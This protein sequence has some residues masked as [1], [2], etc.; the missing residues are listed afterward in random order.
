VEIRNHFTVPLSIERTWLVLLDAPRIAP[1]LPGARLVEVQGPNRYKGEMEVRLGPV[2]LRFTGRAEVIDID[3]AAHR[4]R[5][6]AE[7][8]DAKGRGGAMADVKFEL[9]PRNDETEVS[10]VTSI[11]LTGAVA[12]YGRGSGMIKDL[13]N[14]LVAQFATNLRRELA[15]ELSSAVPSPS[16]SSSATQTTSVAAPLRMERIGLLLVWRAIIRALWRWIGPVR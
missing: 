4:A 2:A 13:A 12:Q 7:G 14:Q 16:P 8:N 3:A 9:V 6:K 5:V 15:G 1:C 10:I 11:N